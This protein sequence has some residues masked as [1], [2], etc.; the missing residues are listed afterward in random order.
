VDVI[1]IEKTS[2]NINSKSVI[3]EF[4]QAGNQLKKQQIE[5]LTQNNFELLAQEYKNDPVSVKRKIKKMPTIGRV[6]YKAL[7]DFLTFNYS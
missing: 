7:V 1:P 5:V 4:I 2:S 6:A 3:E